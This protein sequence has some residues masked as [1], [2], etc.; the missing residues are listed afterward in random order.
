MSRRR[1]KERE[2]PKEGEKPGGPTEPS[3]ALPK[4][5]LPVS[6]GAATGLISHASGSAGGG[7]ALLFIGFMLL[8]PLALQMK[9]GYEGGR[10]WA[11][12]LWFTFNTW[13]L[14]WAGMRMALG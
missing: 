2:K 8:R 6:I 7:I 5:L 1:A 10:E 3:P 13:F 9:V 14:V 11:G 4:A 12:A